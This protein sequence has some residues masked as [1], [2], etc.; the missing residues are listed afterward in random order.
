[1]IVAK[2]KS[3]SYSMIGS[4]ALLF[5]VSGL[6]TWATPLIIR[7]APVY[8]GDSKVSDIATIFG[9]AVV[10]TGIVG[11]LLGGVLAK[12]ILALFVASHGFTAPSVLLC[13]EK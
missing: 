5:A 9:V 7:M 4:S 3:F 8:H 6:G 2:T 10:V 13:K 1:M 11:T 12:V